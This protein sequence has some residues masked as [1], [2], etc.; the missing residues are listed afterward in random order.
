[1][2]FFLRPLGPSILRPR[3]ESY[4]C[5]LRLTAEIE[6]LA[7]LSL[8]SMTIHTNPTSTIYTDNSACPDV[9]SPVRTIPQ[10]SKQF[11]TPGAR[12]FRFPCPPP[13]P[14]RIPILRWGDMPPANS[15]RGSASLQENP[16]GSCYPAP[17]RRSTPSV[18]NAKN[19]RT[20]C[21]IPSKSITR[22]SDRQ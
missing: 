8:V 2:P 5:P 6:I 11:G 17:P 1:M 21:S 7:E 4:R 19:S 9:A 22:P 13:P 15:V 16:A 18:C 3:T 10:K 20:V 14:S 12:R